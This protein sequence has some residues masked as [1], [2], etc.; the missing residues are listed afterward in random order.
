MVRG[1]GENSRK[2][3]I[4][5]EDAAAIIE[6]EGHEMPLSS[7]MSCIRRLSRRLSIVTKPPSTREG[8]H[9]EGVEEE[10]GIGIYVERMVNFVLDGVRYIRKE[11]SGND[12]AFVVVCAVFFLMM[13]LNIGAMRQ[14]M[15]LG[16]SLRE[17]NA[18]LEKIDLNQAILLKLWNDKILDETCSS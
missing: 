15:M 4:G 5:L 6:E 16:R 11:V 1:L 9:L 2:A 8:L 18:R 12:S 7:A 10:R 17:M 3:G 14:M 13:T